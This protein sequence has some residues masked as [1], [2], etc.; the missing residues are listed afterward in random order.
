M[1]AFK[2]LSLNPVFNDST[3][4]TRDGGNRATESRALHSFGNSAGLGYSRHNRPNAEKIVNSCSSSLSLIYS[5]FLVASFIVLTQMGST[6]SYISKIVPNIV[7]YGINYAIALYLVANIRRLRPCMATWSVLLLLFVPFL[8]TSINGGDWFTYL[9]RILPS[10]FMVLMIETLE[11]RG[12]LLVALDIFS[13][14]GVVLIVA[15]L[16]SI[17][18]FPDGM[19]EAELYSDNWL[20]GYKTARSRFGLPALAFSALSSY[21]RCGTLDVRTHVGFI[22]LIASSVLTE[23]GMGT[24]ACIL[25]Y[26]L[27]LAHGALRGSEGGAL[28]LL[29]DYRVWV[30]FIAGASLCVYVLGTSDAM[31]S[32]LVSIGKDPTFTGRTL[33]WGATIDRFLESP[34]LGFGYVNSDAYQL[35][36]GVAGGTQAHSLLLT[37]L[38]LGGLLAVVLLALAVWSAF[39]GYRPRASLSSGSIMGA[40]MA[41][42]ALMGFTSCTFY[43]ALTL[44]SLVVLFYADRAECGVEKNG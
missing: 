10:V 17:F 31:A 34:F 24:A 26:A 1:S 18:V 30:V 36:T 4:T 20:L 2:V 22:A 14:V 44:P 6:E 29:F 37:V 21:R 9:R 35:M 41:A 12:E 39:R 13:D 40:L 43:A 7:Q 27:L 23:S 16:L 28:S 19:Y 3:V 33:I 42:E 25:N 38:G 15:D 11:G 8:S 5:L 32:F